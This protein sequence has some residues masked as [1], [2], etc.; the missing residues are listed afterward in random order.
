MNTKKDYTNIEGYAVILIVTAF[1]SY[2]TGKHGLNNAHGL[3]IIS[4]GFAAIA[5]YAVVEIVKELRR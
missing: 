3:L 2:F 4:A 5:V 1:L